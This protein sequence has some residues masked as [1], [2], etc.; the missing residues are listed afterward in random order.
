V[1]HAEESETCEE[2]GAEGE[3]AEAAEVDHEAEDASETA[4][5]GFDEPG[6]F[7]FGHAGRAEGL[8][9]AVDAADGDEESEDSPNGGGTE[10]E[11]HGDGAGSADE[12]GLFAADA[13]GEEAV[14][15]LS[16]GVDEGRGENDFGHLGIG[17]MVLLGDGFVGDG[18][19]VAAEIEAGVEEAEVTPVEAAAGTKTL[20]IGDG[21]FNRYRLSHS[22]SRSTSVRSEGVA[23]SLAA[24]GY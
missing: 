23:R 21:V 7:D 11:V 8:E 12:H 2:R 14:E 5:F 15:D 20:R 16:E 1:D 18:E 3:D 22:A 19:V 10:E 9:V 24:K 17:E 13:V 4:P 6:G